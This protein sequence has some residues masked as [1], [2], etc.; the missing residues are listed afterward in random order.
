MHEGG[1]QDLGGFIDGGVD[2]LEHGAAGQ[3][4]DEYV[5]EQDVDDQDSHGARERQLLHAEGKIEGDDVANAED[6]ARRD[7]GLKGKQHTDVVSIGAT[8]MLD[9][10]IIIKKRRYHV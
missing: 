8:V 10:D 7:A 5:P 9:S 4:A 1:A 3:H 6:H 2:T